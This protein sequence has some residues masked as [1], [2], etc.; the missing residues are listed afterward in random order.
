MTLSLDAV[1]K[2]TAPRRFSYGWRDC[3][4]YA[5]GV[6]AT[7]DDLRYV[8]EMEGPKVLPTFAVV[9]AFEPMV[10]ALG[11][12]G[13]NIAMLVHGAQTVELEGPLPP[14]G[15]IETTAVVEG[16]YDKEKGALAVIGTESRAPGGQPI[17][18]TSWQLYFRGMG[19]FGG[20]RGP[21]PPPNLPPEGAA[22]DRGVTSATSPTQA[23]LYRLSGDVNPI[24]VSPE[25]AALVGFERPILHGL[26]VYGFAARA[27]IDWYC[28]GRPE[29]FRSFHARFAKV[30]Y[31]GDDLRIEA[32][33][34]GP[35]ALVR[36]T[37]P[38]REVPVLTHGRMQVR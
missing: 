6:G 30:T 26:C 29:R 35:D 1:G 7:Q 28:E 22:P 17:A 14:E 5:L 25:I 38:A 37:V 20:P 33:R 2:R 32:W 18:R 3:V 24:H 27:A 12:I 31:P 16:I 10:E 11:M 21:E 4:L 8:S 15:T 19:G 13:G 36:V 34:D 23:I 9:P